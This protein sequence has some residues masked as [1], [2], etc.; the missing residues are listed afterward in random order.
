M[1]HLPGLSFKTQQPTILAQPIILSGSIFI[2]S[3]AGLNADL[4]ISI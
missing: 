1:N 3:A 4:K 2:W